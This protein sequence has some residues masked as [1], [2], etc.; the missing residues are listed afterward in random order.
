MHKHLNEG[1]VVDDTLERL[2]RDTSDDCAPLRQNCCDQ[3]QTGLDIRRSA[4][5]TFVEETQVLFFRIKRDVVRPVQFPT[6]EQWKKKAE[7][8]GVLGGV[9]LGVGH[10]ETPSGIFSNWQMCRGHL[11]FV[12]NIHHLTSFSCNTW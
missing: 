12:L 1:D 11:H 8:H 7:S 9:F 6:S 5:H 3:L 2:W 10:L 4:K